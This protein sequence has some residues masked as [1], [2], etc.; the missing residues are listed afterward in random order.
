MELNEKFQNE[1]KQLHGQ[2]VQLQS[3]NRKL[4]SQLLNSVISS[5][6]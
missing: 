1:M 6:E 5:N 4:K 2:I 3:S